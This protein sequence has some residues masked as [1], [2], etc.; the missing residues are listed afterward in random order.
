MDWAVG[1]GKIDKSI[2]GFINT[3]Q[4]LLYVDEKI[5]LETEQTPDGYRM[6]NEMMAAGAVPKEL[7][8]E[9]F[10]GLIGKAAGLAFRQYLDQNY[11]RPVAG[12]DVLNNYAKVAP[13]VKKQKDQ[14][15][16]MHSTVQ[17]VASCLSNIK[18]MSVDQRKNLIQFILDIGDE[19]GTTLINKM[20]REFLTDIATDKRLVQKVTDA[21]NR[22]E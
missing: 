18:K 21:L 20:P 11:E 5:E 16:M 12:E 1:P 10:L 19:S 8:A 2:T 15:A 13:K 6:L 4:A 9:V 14:N 7:E 17:E 3:H 22:A